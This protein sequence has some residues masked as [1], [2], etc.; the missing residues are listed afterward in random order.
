MRTIIFIL[1]LAVLAPSTLAAAGDGIECDLVANQGSMCRLCI[2]NGSGTPTTQC[3]SCR[4][5]FGLSFSSASTGTCTRCSDGMGATGGASTAPQLA[6]NRG[7]AVSCSACHPGCSRCVKPNSDPQGASSCYRCAAGVWA[8]AYDSNNDVGT[9]AGVCADRTTR[10]VAANDLRDVETAAVC[11]GMCH[12]SCASFMGTGADKCT[13]CS[14]G[15]YATGFASGTATCSPCDAG[16]T[17][18]VA[19]SVLTGNEDKAT[20]CFACDKSCASCT[21]PSANACT[22]CAAGY[23]LSARTGSETVGTCT[24][25]TGGKTKDADAAAFTST[26]S[27]STAAACTAMCTAA[28]N[29]DSCSAADLGKCTSCATGFTLDATTKV[30]SKPATTPGTSSSS[31]KSAS[32]LGAFFGVSIASYILF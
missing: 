31:S 18:A 24:A 8:T 13:K 25:C 3:Y 6:A 16:T 15:T 4:D 21:G 5:G 29:C 20:T 19:A 7:S 10:D 30:C 2:D 28:S 14:A 9:C 26:T 22:K 1:V 17:R 12:A 23:Y 11:T 32:L 27:V